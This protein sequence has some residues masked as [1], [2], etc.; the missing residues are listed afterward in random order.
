M[1]YR[2]P[3]RA[4]LEY[5]R[6]TRRAN[7]PGVLQ[8]RFAPILPPGQLYVRS[9][10]RAGIDLSTTRWLLAVSI[11]PIPIVRPAFHIA[12]LLSLDPRS[13]WSRR[14]KRLTVTFYL[15]VTA[16]RIITKLYN[17]K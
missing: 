16:L 2:Q 9:T 10:V 6:V 14:V 5:K 8:C 7:G 1:P 17:F 12:L 11:D 4:P 15:R 3:P 13:G